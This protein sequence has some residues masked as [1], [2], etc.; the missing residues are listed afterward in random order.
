MSLTDLSLVALTITA[1]I[2][3]PVYFHFRGRMS[4][5][6]PQFHF[7]KKRVVK[8]TTINIALLFIG[9]VQFLGLYLLAINRAGT[10]KIEYAVL[11]IFLIFIIGLIFYGSGMYITSIVLES[12][13]IPEL[14]KSDFFKTQ[15]KA[16]K[17]FHHPMSHVLV[18]SGW[19]FA[20]LILA[21]LNPS[22]L[23]L[24]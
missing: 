3:T 4:R 13:A 19:M 10:F 11:S 24:C 18:F 6:H 23:F 5:S 1:I 2:A 17:L 20:M 9:F 8:I 14:T 22:P 12:Y 15:L 7:S 16:M 21:F